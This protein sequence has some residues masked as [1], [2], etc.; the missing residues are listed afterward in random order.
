M[1]LMVVFVMLEWKSMLFLVIQM[2]TS[3]GFDYGFAIWA[4][5]ADLKVLVSLIQ[6]FVL[7]PSHF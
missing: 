4:D 1:I 7:A 6:A 3:S 5:W 2:V